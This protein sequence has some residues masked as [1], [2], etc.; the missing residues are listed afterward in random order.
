MVEVKKKEVDYS[1][2][3]PKEDAAPVVAAT[4]EPEVPSVPTPEPELFRVADWSGLPNYGCPYCEWKTLS[5]ANDV[6][7]H[8]DGYH[9][10][11]ALADV[12]RSN[13][14]NGVQ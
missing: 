1:E 8:I 9:R 14:E 6:M 2:G 12:A 7:F 3:F 11:Q 5:G 10:D 4:P 13:D